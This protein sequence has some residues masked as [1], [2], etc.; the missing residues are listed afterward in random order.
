[1]TEMFLLLYGRHV[2]APLKGTNKALKIGVE[3][4]PNNAPMNNR[5]ELGEVIN[6]SITFHISG[7]T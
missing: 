5:T 2:G 7:F 1:M 6:I 4:F 3:H